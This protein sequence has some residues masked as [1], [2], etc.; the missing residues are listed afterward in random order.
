MIQL[1]SVLSIQIA[2]SVG[3]GLTFA[4]I[5]LLFGINQMVRFVYLCDVII[6]LISYQLL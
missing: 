4:F 1:V 3:F 6:C 5:A 2:C